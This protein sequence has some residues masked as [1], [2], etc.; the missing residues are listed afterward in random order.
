MHM[1]KLFKVVIKT[2]KICEICSKLT[3]KMPVSF[4]S[5]S[6]FDPVSKKRYEYIISFTKHLLYLLSDTNKSTEKA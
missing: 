3:I 2:R 5:L 4:I 1:K 6:D